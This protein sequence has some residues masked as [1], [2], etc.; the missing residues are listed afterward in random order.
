M[1][2]NTEHVVLDGSVLEGG[3]QILRNAMSYAAILRRSL[4]IDKI[5]VGRD[6]PGLK[7]QHAAGL[8]L[9][10]QISEGSQFEGADVKSQSIIFQP[11]ITTSGHYTA[12]PQTAGS[13][14]LLLQI[15]LPCLICLP[16]DSYSTLTLRGGTNAVQAPQVD[17]IQRV[18]LPFLKQHFGID[19]RLDIKQRGYWPKG[20]G[21]LHV[22]VP[23][24]SG[25]LLPMDLKERGK[26]ISVSGIAYVA[27]SL[28]QHL[29]HE[30]RSSA[31]DCMRDEGHL[32]GVHDITVDILKDQNCIGSGM[33]IVLVARTNTG[34]VLAGSALGVKGKSVKEVGEEAARELGKNLLEG[35]CVDEYM[36][37]QMIIFLALAGGR[38]T[39]RTGPLTLHTK[40]A[41]WVAEQMTSAR[42]TIEEEVDRHGVAT[43]LIHCDGI[44]WSYIP[45]ADRDP[46]ETC[47]CAI[48]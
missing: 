35:G 18:F 3:G 39:I 44:G 19:V 40:A 26:V 33:G 46:E 42:F 48:G 2:S 36:Q 11:G 38:S 4:R 28:P 6:Q 13:T 14:T 7:A 37:D 41:I 8:V 17:Y 20:G 43:N 27:G 5:R 1:T 23:S 21:E 30:L 32:A 15:S 25:T 29:V 22:S 34:C 16:P 45:P 10:S 9:V 31:L 24:I 12:D 47:I